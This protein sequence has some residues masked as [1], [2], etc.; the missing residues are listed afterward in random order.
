MTWR[1]AELLRRIS[2]TS[3]AQSQ[4]RRVGGASVE[5]RWSVG[6]ASVLFFGE[7]QP[8]KTVRPSFLKKDK[9]LEWELDLLPKKMTI[10]R[11]RSIFWTFFQVPNLRL[12]LAEVAL[13]SELQ[14][15][16][17]QTARNKPAPGNPW[18]GAALASFF[19][20]YNGVQKFKNFCLDVFWDVVCTF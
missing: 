1:K 18:L 16:M 9:R 8:N 7:E 11:I 13:A 2:G 4:V 12:G 3:D 17:L 10:P 20:S 5:R 15:L 6:G 19:F 14:K